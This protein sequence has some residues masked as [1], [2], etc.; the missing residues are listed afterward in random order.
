MPETTGRGSESVL[1]EDAP[2]TK[3]PYHHGD[4]RNAIITEATARARAQGPQAIVLREIAAQIGVSATAAY[5]HFTNRQQLVEEVSVRGV[6]AVGED[7]FASGV[8]GA[9]ADAGLAAYVDLRNACFA[10]VEFT[11][12]ESGW[13]RMMYETVWISTT[14]AQ[15]SAVNE[16]RLQEIVD[17]GIDAGMFLP[18]T[19]IGG[20]RVFWAG[21]NGLCARAMFET[22]PADPAESGRVTARVVDLC[23]TDMLTEPGKAARDAVVLPDGRV[24][25]LAEILR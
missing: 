2:A 16:S 25:D 6:A 1:T 18:G 20:N 8:D 15:A 3:R 4:L 10:L 22:D 7:M 12:T 5:R 21:V 23:A 11:A 9:E 13:S 19:E 24:G 17:R 14:V